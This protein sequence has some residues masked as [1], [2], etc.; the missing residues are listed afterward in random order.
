MLFRFFLND[1]F[2]LNKQSKKVVKSSKRVTFAIVISDLMIAN[3]YKNGCVTRSHILI[4][5]STANIAQPFEKPKRKRLN[6][7][8]VSFGRDG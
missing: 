6:V 1:R 5:C 7:S 2:R 8:G 4:R 3:G